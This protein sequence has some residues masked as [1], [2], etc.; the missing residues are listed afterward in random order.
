[1]ASKGNEW[2]SATLHVAG[3]ICLQVPPILAPQRFQAVSILSKRMP[4]PAIIKAAVDKLDSDKLKPDDV[5]PLINGAPL[6]KHRKR[7]GQSTISDGMG[8]T[9]P[10]WA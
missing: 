3:D 2:R 7:L 8:A 10:E 6:L 5:E 9:D 4:P 1:M